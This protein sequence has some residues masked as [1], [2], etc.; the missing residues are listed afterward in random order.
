[1]YIIAAYDITLNEGGARRLSKI[2]KLFRQYL[3]HTQKSVFEGEITSAKFNEL[4]HKTNLIIDKEA[5]YVLFF[6]VPNSKNIIKEHLGVDFD[7]T[8]NILD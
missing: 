6:N 7:A 5:D 8:T 1:M 4:K 3:H 2:L